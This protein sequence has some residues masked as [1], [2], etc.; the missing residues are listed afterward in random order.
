MNL[1]PFPRKR[2]SEHAPAADN[3][4][5]ATP[6]AANPAAGLAALVAAALAARAEVQASPRWTA[7]PGGRIELG[8]TGFQIQ[9]VTDARQDPYTAFD[10]EG[11]R[12]ATG[13]HLDAL[14]RFA[15]QHAAWRAEFAL[16]DDRSTP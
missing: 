11:R 2:P 4:A 14:K 12:M 3:P 6:P 16:P 9:L 13:F 1:W 7:L 5:P 10:P 8:C 15:E